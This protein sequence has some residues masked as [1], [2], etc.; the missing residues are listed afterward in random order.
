MNIKNDEKKEKT[1]FS[2]IKAKAPSQKTE[3]DNIFNNNAITTNN[4]TSSNNDFTNAFIPQ[5]TTTYPE[6]VDLTKSK[7]C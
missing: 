1:G 4:T 2:F 5:N 7:R 6:T 3:L